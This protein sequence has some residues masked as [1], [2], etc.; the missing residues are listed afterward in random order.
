MESAH[1]RASAQVTI[2]SAVHLQAHRPC[3]LYI[4]W[5]FTGSLL[6]LQT[7]KD[8]ITQNHHSFLCHTRSLPLSAMVCTTCIWILLHMRRHAHAY[9]HCTSTY[10]ILWRA[11]WNKIHHI[12]IRAIWCVNRSDHHHVNHVH[13]YH[14]VLFSD[15]SHQIT[16][17]ILSSIMLP[18]LH[19]VVTFPRYNV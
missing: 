10:A 1:S 17:C 4:Y 9:V 12:N 3:T 16:V 7:S 8:Y 6:F 2:L 18:V 13:P 11:T 15:I 5:Y 14:T 19:P